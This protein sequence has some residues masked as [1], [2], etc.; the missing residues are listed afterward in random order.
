MDTQRGREVRDRVELGA[1]A[2][3]SDPA[4]QLVWRVVSDER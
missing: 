2:P 3:A 4:D 1:V